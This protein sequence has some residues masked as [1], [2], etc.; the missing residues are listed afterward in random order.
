MALISM[1]TLPLLQEQHAPSAS[2]GVHQTSEQ[3]WLLCQTV[4]YT[5]MRI[6]SLGNAVLCFWTRLIE[7]VFTA[8]S[9][10]PVTGTTYYHY[11]T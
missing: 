7:A 8:S 11:I 6:I 9:G 3:V 2:A 10:K 4:V 5:C 1:S